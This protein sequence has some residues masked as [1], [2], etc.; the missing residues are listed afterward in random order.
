[1]YVHVHERK[2]LLPGQAQ[3]SHAPAPHQQQAAPVRSRSTC[4]PEAKRC[5]Q[6]CCPHQQEQLHGA[7]AQHARWQLLH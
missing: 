6:M 2:E 1:M 7:T 3:C 5:A 4:S